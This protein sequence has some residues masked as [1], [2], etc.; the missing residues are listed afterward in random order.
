LGISLHAHAIRNKFLPKIDAAMDCIIRLASRKSASTLFLTRLRDEI[1]PPDTNVRSRT[2]FERVRSAKKRFITLLRSKLL[3]QELK[4]LGKKWINR[5]NLTRATLLAALSCILPVAAAHATP[6]VYTFSG[7][8]GG[9][10]N[11]TAFTGDFSVVFDSDTTAVQPFGSEYIVSNVGGTFTE[12]SSTYTMD[13]IF[14]I[15]ANPDPAFPRVGFFNSDITNGLL[16]N[17]NAF[18]GY[19][20]ATSIGPVTAPSSDPTSVLY[21]TLGGTTGFSL[22]GGADTLIFTSDESLT[23][24]AAVES[25]VPEPSSLVLFAAGL[26]GIALIYRRSGK[27]T[28]CGRAANS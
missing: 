26:L 24:S 9:T 28:A 21:P 2:N 25:P 13:P 11:G 18:A 16:I 23:F 5:K 12:G 22:D 8:G 20:L 1:P 10:I 15:I 6:I 27:P 17:N 7:V 3:V 4:M 19:N 14:G